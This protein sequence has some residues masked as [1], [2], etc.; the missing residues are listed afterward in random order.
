MANLSTKMNSF[1]P[2]GPYSTFQINIE[3]H[4]YAYCT[5]SY[6]QQLNEMLKHGNIYPIENICIVKCELMELKQK[7]LKV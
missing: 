3:S 2:L 7:I 5:G 6:I 4:R 1:E